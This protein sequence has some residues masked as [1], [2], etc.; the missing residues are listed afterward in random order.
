MAYPTHTIICIITSMINL[1]IIPACPMVAMAI[2]TGI[3]TAVAIH[4]HACYTATCLSNSFDNIK[5][6]TQMTKGALGIMD[7]T[8]SRG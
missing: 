8:A 3:I 5:R 1:M 2:T 7:I 6:C 4:R